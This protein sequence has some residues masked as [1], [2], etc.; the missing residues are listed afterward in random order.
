[1]HD[2][3]VI[4]LWAWLFICT[5]WMVC[6]TFLDCATSLLSDSLWFA[7]STSL[8]HGWIRF[9]HCLLLLVF[10]ILV[11]FGNVRMEDS[12]MVVFFLLSALLLASTIGTFA[13]FLF[14]FGLLTFDEESI[15]LKQCFS[16]DRFRPTI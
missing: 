2:K 11:E 13:C 7:T 1:M 14:F 15:E 16:D 5:V 12:H 6:E 4:A 3:V 10:Q 9:F 8:A